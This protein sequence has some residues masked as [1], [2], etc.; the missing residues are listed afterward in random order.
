MALHQ[1]LQ[2]IFWHPVYF[3]QYAVTQEEQCPKRMLSLPFTAYL[4]FLFLKILWSMWHPG[5]TRAKI[6]WKQEVVSDHLLMSLNGAVLV[7][8]VG[9]KPCIKAEMNMNVIGQAEERCNQAGS[10]CQDVCVEELASQRDNSE[11]EAETTSSSF[12]SPPPPPHPLSTLYSHSG[13]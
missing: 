9:G 5:P 3:E 11:K 2:C 6:R 12:S 4:F 13:R 10:S 1:S 8:P 7:S